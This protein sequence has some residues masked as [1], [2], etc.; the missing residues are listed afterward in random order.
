MEKLPLWIHLS[1]IPLEL[2][3]QKGLS[4]IASAVGT[5]L[6]MD[7]ITASQHR[8]AFAKVCVEIE[9]VMEIPRFIKVGM[10]DGSVVIVNIHV[11]W[12]PLKCLHCSTF[13]HVAKT[14]PKKPVVAAP[15]VW[16]PKSVIKP[17]GETETMRKQ[18]NEVEG[19]KK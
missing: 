6:Y 1:N 18:E 16:I 11:P 5:P 10:R 13:G 4:Y 15:K 12:Y 3:T 2:F 9:S 19:N 7:R 14:C 8:Q 17:V